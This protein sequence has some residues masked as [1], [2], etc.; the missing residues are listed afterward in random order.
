VTSAEWL[1]R[2]GTVGRAYGATIH[3]L[4]DNGREVSPGTVGSVHFASSAALV[5]HNDPAKTAAAHDALGRATIG[6]IGYVD[7]DGYLFLTDR[8]AFTIISGGVNIY[9]AEVEAAFA[10]HPDIVD[11]AVFGVPDAD[12]GEAVFALVELPHDV[13]A[14]SATARSLEAYARTRLAGPKRP[15]RIA[16]GAVGRTETGKIHKAQLRARV[17]DFVSFDL[18]LEPVA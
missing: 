6:D 12:L 5:Y 9:P 3:I 1:A 14:D 2:P 11:I 4:D 10:G 17:D 13:A 16:F 18:R 15:R 7:A 8:R